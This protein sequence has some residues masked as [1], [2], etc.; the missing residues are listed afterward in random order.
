MTTPPKTPG[1]R[2]TLSKIVEAQVMLM[3]RVSAERSSVKLTR[4]AKGDTQIEVRVAIGENGV[5]SAEAANS[6]AQQIYD[7][8]TA[9]YDIQAGPAVRD[10]RDGDGEP[11]EPK[12]KARARRPYDPRPAANRKRASRSGS[13]DD[14]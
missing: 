13:R 2:L 7:A 12:A 10:Y 8:L 4:N 5:D 3:G 1:N 9:K 14:G 6:K 11:A